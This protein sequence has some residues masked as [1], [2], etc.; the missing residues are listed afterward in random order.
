VSLLLLIGNL[1]AADGDVKRA[2]SG[3]TSINAASLALLIGA[4]IVSTMLTQAFEFE[5]IRALEG[6]WGHGPLITLF[7]DWRCRR[8]IRRRDALNTERRSVG[9]RAFAVAGQ[10]MLRRGVPE[11]QVRVIGAERAGRSVPEATDDDRR[12]A[13]QRSWERYAPGADIRR[14]DALWED[15]KSYPTQDRLVRPTRLGN[16]LRAHEE[17]V[18]A[19]APGDLGRLGPAGISPASGEDPGATR[20]VPVSA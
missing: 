11:M 3:I 15:A 1:S 10:E 9:D 2:I 7:A 4:V 8:S 20:P 18:L 13:R 16:V 14:R 19:I 17:R 6:Y 12:L 5:A